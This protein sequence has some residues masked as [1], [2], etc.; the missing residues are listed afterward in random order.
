MAHSANIASSPAWQTRSS[1]SPAS[2]SVFQI[3]NQKE[4]DLANANILLIITFL[5]ALT[6]EQAI[7]EAN[8]S[9]I[10]LYTDPDKNARQ[11]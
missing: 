9:P 2:H 4:S 11:L 5:L 3:A 7:A 1:N 8:R 10:I 6:A